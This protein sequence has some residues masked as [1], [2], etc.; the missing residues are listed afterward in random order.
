M[1]KASLVD[2][3]ASEFAV[4]PA[5][6]RQ[7]NEPRVDKIAKDFKP[8]M[9][10][11][12]TAS[13]RL[14]GRTYILDGQHRMAA[15]R[16]KQYDGYIATRVYEGLT[17]AEEAELF[18]DLNNT[19]KV[20]ALDKFHVR[21][22]KGDPAA[23]ALKEALERV[24]LRASGQHTAGMF[25]AIV[26]LERVYQGFRSF[27]AEPRLDLVESTLAILTRAYGTAERKAF[28]ANTVQ[29]IGLILHIFGK[30]VDAEDLTQALKT[31]PAD[32]LAIRGRSTK[33]L[34]GG[35]GAQGVAK[36]ILS[37]YNKGKSAN[38]LEFHEFSDGLAKLR[39]LDNE[40]FELTRGPRPRK[41]VAG[42]STTQAKVVPEQALLPV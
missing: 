25:A 11:L 28:Q 32:T 31:I 15:C 29:G 41:R 2:M 13:K 18:L 37:K 23:V 35:T 8:M 9:L 17:L 33:D 19:R 30:R 21:A 26:S 14:D 24:G 16:K 34:E 39:K 1:S 38:R 22:T 20:S 12:F 42:E 5:V 7:L 40:A 4:D 3:K 10:G 6:Q 36:V 27:G